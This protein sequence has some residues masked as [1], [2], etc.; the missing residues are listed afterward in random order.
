LKI[1]TWNSEWATPAD[2]RGRTIREILHKTESDVIVLTEGCRGLLPDDG[3]IIEGSNDWGYEVT[4]PTRRK[5]IIWS[6]HPI[7]EYDTVGHPNMPTGR[8]VTAI[9]ELDCKRVRIVGVCIPW[10]GAHV[11]TGRRDR[12]PWE[13]H[14][15]YLIALTEQLGLYKERLILAGDFNQRIPR[16]RQPVESHELLTAVLRHLT[17]HTASIGEPSLIDHVATTH[18][19]AYGFHQIL[20]KVVGTDRVTD[21][22]GVSMNLSHMNS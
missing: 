19:L 8:F 12:R 21:H 11:S 16:Q 15:T 3:H 2:S 1:T 14:N 18:N 22:F 6:R 13:D 10:S 20:P 17:V 4:D 5:V 9:T 7:Y